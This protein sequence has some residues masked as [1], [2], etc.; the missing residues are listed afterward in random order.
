VAADGTGAGGGPVDH[1]YMVYDADGGLRGELAYLVGTLRGRHCG[2][3]EVTHGRLRRRAA[4]DEFT[5]TLAVPVDV[6]HRNEQTPEVA[7]FTDGIT[8]V[9]VGR[10]AGRLTVLLDAATLASFHG[11]V[12][13]FAAALTAELDARR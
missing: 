3:C 11:D 13:R 4:F 5:C 12:D 9:V 10:V 7:A 6:W 8:P 1:L 2:L